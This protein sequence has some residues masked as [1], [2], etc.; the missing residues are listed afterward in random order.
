MA[1]E[2]NSF[3][4]GICNSIYSATG[5]NHIFSSVLYTSIMLSITIILVI[6]LLYPGK[7]GT[8]V[9][10]I[11]KLFLYIMMIIT[12]V[13]SIH[14]SFIKNNYKEKY[15]NSNVSDLMDNIHGGRMYNDEKISVQPHLDSYKIGGE[16]DELDE[17]NENSPDGKR[18]S[19]SEMIDDLERK[20]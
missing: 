3:F 1:I 14:N 13:F 18:L 9:W 15:L 12:V 2:I 4:G 19:L 17:I 11:F 8:P 6:M 20:V 7:K 16:I 5:L 10:V